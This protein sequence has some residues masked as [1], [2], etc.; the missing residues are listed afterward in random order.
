MYKTT[1]TYLNHA[2]V[3]LECDGH[4]IWTDPFY[5]SPAFGSW[6]SSPPL[7]INPSY[8]LSILISNPKKFLILISHGH[9]D[10]CDDKLIS[11]FKNGHV[12][13]TSYESPG[14]VKRISRAGFKEIIKLQD[15]EYEFGPFKLSGFVNK[16]YSRD[17]SIQMITS[18]E[19]SFI[20]AND[21]WFEWDN[22]IWEK[23]NKKK[24]GTI[25]HASQVQN[26]T[27]SYPFAY[28][29]FS[30]AEA[31]I[32]QNQ[33]ILNH[34][35]GVI[36]NFNKI[37]ADHFL[38]YAGHVK[39]FSDNQKVNMLSGSI[40][41]NALRKMAKSIDTKFAEK[42]LDMRAG[43]SFSNGLLTRGIG[44]LNTT[45]AQSK[46]AS[47]IFWEEYSENLARDLPSTLS[48]NELSTLLRRFSNEFKKYVLT[49]TLDLD[50][51]RE[52][53]KY[54]ISIEISNLDKVII[55]FPEFSNSEPLEFTTAWKKNIAEGI[56]TGKINWEVSYVGANG[57]HSKNPG[58]N[59]DISVV[60]WLT[61]FAYRWENSV[62]GH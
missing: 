28:N 21:C 60:R 23:I 19:L 7:Y 37:K 13:T 62:K 43:D 56:L 3:L 20:H 49:R 29:N 46:E 18:E 47:V 54:K 42:I 10:H 61:M 33:F 5:S 40:E 17:D 41:L 2:S 24:K 52:I 50:Y 6:L 51:F 39:I 59:N 31:E 25:V 9:D 30:N 15:T 44:N 58:H 48:N 27:G 53:L 14:V 35:N 26:A 4:Y 16:N 38:N 34:L 11:L 8:L 32:I 45:E 55:E 1:I 57:V 22:Y 36:K 12:A